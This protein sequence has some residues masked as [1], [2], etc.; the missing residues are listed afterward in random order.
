M[1]VKSSCLARHIKEFVLTGGFNDYSKKSKIVS[2]EAA[3]SF[4]FAFGDTIHYSC[5]PTSILDDKI[6]DEVWVHVLWSLFHII[7]PPLREGDLAYKRRMVFSLFVRVW[8]RCKE[9]VQ[10]RYSLD[11]V[12]L[13]WV[14]TVCSLGILCEVML[15]YRVKTL[16]HW[17]LIFL[18]FCIK[19]T[20]VL[21]GE[22]K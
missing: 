5:L 13:N 12:R 16:P 1:L 18:K 2:P 10:S 4:C 11:G 8:K 7:V 21:V 6:D 22:S 19:T 9:I 20:T 17:L 15:R 14:A 3:L